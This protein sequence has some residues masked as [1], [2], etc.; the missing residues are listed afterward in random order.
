[1]R[2][3][4]WL[5]LS[6]IGTP[7]I[8]DD[9]EKLKKI[10]DGSCNKIIASHILEHLNYKGTGKKRVEKTIKILKLWKR[11]L[12][13]GGTLFISVPNLDVIIDVLN[14]HKDD[15]W[16]LDGVVDGKDI[17]GPIFGAMDTEYNCHSMLYNYKCLEHCLK[18]AGFDNIQL[19]SDTSQLIPIYNPSTEDYRSLNIRAD[20]RLNE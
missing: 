15:Y 7:D 16:L 17:I 6:P 12:K 4:G 20:R 19:V 14:K 3:L 13:P 5:S 11:K 9:A 2:H 8:F 1:M 10:K 18:M